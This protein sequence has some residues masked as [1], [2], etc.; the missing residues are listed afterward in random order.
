MTPP[1]PALR[2]QHRDWPMLLLFALRDSRWRVA[3]VQLVGS[4]ECASPSPIR[5][6]AIGSRYEITDRELSA[7]LRVLEERPDTRGAT[8]AVRACLQRESS[9]TFV[10]T[11]YQSG[12]PTFT[13]HELTFFEELWRVLAEQG[14]LTRLPP[15]IQT[16]GT[17]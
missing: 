5:V 12:P 17:P 3:Q 16:G 4:V 2:D 10:G 14:W 8:S 15:P 11:T 13:A 6:L 7:A 9:Y 1:P